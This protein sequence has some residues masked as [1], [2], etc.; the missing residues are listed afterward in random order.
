MCRAGLYTSSL[1]WLCLALG[2]LAREAPYEPALPDGQEVLKHFNLSIVPFFM[3]STALGEPYG[4]F[5]T[6]RCNNG[7]PFNAKSP[8]AELVSREWLVSKLGRQYTRMISRQVFTYGVIFHLT[9]NE[10]ALKH[11][12]A[13]ARYIQ[14]Y[15]MDD[16][17][18]VITYI[19][20]DGKPG[21]APEQRTSQDLAYAQ[22]GL[23]MLY[24]LT[25]DPGILSDLLR[26][27]KYIFAHYRD[28]A[29]DMLK[30]VLADSSEEKANQ[31][32]LVAQLD[33][34][35]AYMLL[36]YPLL[37]EREKLQ[38]RQDM[39][40]L[41]NVLRSQYHADDELRFYGYLH[42]PSGKLH[43]SRHG[44]FGHTSKAYWMLYLLGRELADR[45]LVSWSEKGLLS[46]LERAYGEVEFLEVLGNERERPKG[47]RMSDR[48]GFW[49]SHENTRGAAWWEYAE[50]D[51]AAWTLSLS[52]PQLDHKIG[53]T[54]TTWMNAMVDYQY[55]GTWLFLNGVG[56]PKA[57]HWKNGYHESER[58]LVIYLL[59]QAKNKQDAEL[60]FALPKNARRTARPYYFRAESIKVTEVNQQVQKI[61]FSSVN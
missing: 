27:K 11:A 22:L 56:S 42:D 54:Y 37:P 41:A 12:R 43:Q 59:S 20:K 1:I 61:T 18:G 55:G 10:E 52:Y 3:Q 50:L 23:A 36:L 35:N 15:L 4:N 48:T 31:Q 29:N 7:L 49:N 33:Q 32:E 14:K 9:G 30:W 44:D 58:S 47:V 51:Q 24:Y 6:F 2:V 53:F 13:G 5:P 21:F 8:C 38:W 25:S 39:V 40:W 60:Y 26:V 28:T 17:Q 19:G 46:V 57:F 34:I 16:D 45:E